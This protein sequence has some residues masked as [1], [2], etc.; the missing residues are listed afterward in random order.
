M[1]L[2]TVLTKVQVFWNFK[3]VMGLLQS[4]IL[5]DLYIFAKVHKCFE[6]TITKPNFDR[7]IDIF[8]DLENFT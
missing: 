8:W 2:T 5:W 6:M 1:E 3:Y 4:N 7:T